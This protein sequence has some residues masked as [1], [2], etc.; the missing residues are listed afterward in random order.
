VA[1]EDGSVVT[2]STA[3]PDE[4]DWVENRPTRGRRAL[5]VREVWR[6]REV[7][8]FL[9]LRDL[10]IRYKQ[11]VLGIGWT[12]LQ[13]LAGTA[14]FTVVFNR[15]AHVTSGP[16]PYVAFSLLGFTVW[17]YFSVSLTV[18]TESFVRNSALITKAYFPRIAAPMAAVLP[19]LVGL[20][21]SLV[22]V[23][24]F[25][26]GYRIVPGPS[27]VTLPLWIVALVLVTFGAG[28]LLATINVKYRD[29]SNA[30]ALLL[31]LWLF[32]SPVAYPSNLVHGHWQYLYALNPMVGVLDGFRWALFD[33][34]RPGGPDLVS[35]AMIVVLLF[36]AL[37]YFQTVERRFADVI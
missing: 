4:L 22:V 18:T 28:L 8:A 9:A 15:L 5:Q 21:V 20:G 12:V 16:I 24:A 32:A 35:L 1:V 19:A 29:A 36:V 23:G 25:M 30:Y 13:P 27:L 26:I 31:Q 2:A 6:Y 14:I 37:R 11:A 34:A 10:K 7:T 3:E 17:T 33:T